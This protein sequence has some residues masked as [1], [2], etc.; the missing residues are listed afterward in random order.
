MTTQSRNQKHRKQHISQRANAIQ[1]S[2]IRKFFDL[3]SSIDG[4]ISLGVGE[5]D[6]TTPWHIRESA[7][8]SIE[9]GQTMY[10]SN[11]GMPE[12]RKELARFLKTEFK[13]DYDPTSELLITVGCS[14]ALDLTMR[15]HCRPRRR[16]HYPESVFCSIRQLRHAGR[17][18]AG[19][20]PDQ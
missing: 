14:E 15:A 20:H 16:G 3:L 6:Y 18:Q 19:A 13:V 5:P 2:G 8:E 4:V 12:L 17:R 1:P 11:S 7:I 10:T 9:K